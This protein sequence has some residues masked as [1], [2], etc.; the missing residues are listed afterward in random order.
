M[1]MREFTELD[2][3]QITGRG[4]VIIVPPVDFL[5]KEIVGQTVSIDDTIYF[6]LAYE[7]CLVNHYDLET[8]EEIPCWKPLGLLVKKL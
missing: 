8:G 3:F 4:T 1:S 5:P 7:N 2:R 6:V